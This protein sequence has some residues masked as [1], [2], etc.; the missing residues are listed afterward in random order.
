MFFFGEPDQIA[1]MI[2]MEFVSGFGPPKSEKPLE[3]Q[4]EDELRNTITYARVY[5]QQAMRYGVK[6]DVLNILVDQYDVVF[7]RLAE[8]SPSFREVVLG[9]AHTYLIP[10]SNE[11]AVKYN[12]IVKQFN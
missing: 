11:L 12:N 10:N 5:C 6:E 8:I 4:T 2:K 9:G 3:E 1:E 7:T